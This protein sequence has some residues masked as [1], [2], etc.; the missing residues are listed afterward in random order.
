MVIIRSQ[1][2]PLHIE[3]FWDWSPGAIKP[4]AFILENG[5]ARKHTDVEPD[6]IDEKN[7]WFGI[8]FQ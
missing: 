2:I 6:F 3:I 1:F 4:S 7:F 5:H 8:R